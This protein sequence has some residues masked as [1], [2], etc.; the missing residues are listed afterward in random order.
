MTAKGEKTLSKLLRVNHK[1]VIFALGF[2]FKPMKVTKQLLLCAMAAMMFASCAN[3]NK[4]MKSSDADYK[5]EVA[6]QY[7]MRGKYENASLLLNDV[8]ASM[9]GTDKSDESLFLLGMCKYNSGDMVAANDYFSKYYTTY[10]SG[11]HVEE[12]YFYS[13]M[14]LFLST[15]E[16]SLDQT[17]TYNAVT[18]FQNFIEAYPQSKFAAEAR[19]L[20]FDLQDKLVEKE[21]LSAQLYYNLGDYFGNCTMGGSN[22]EAAIITAQNAIRDYPYTRRKEDFSILILRAKYDLAMRSIES[23]MK[24]RYNDAINDYYGFVNEYPKSK[25]MDEAKKIYEKAQKAIK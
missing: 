19:K 11:I 25:Y 4:V 2:C 22:Y 15:V 5:Y 16:P 1:N 17:A 6:K 18:E 14:S 20:I 10:T 9:K 24:D 8:L 21:Y 3:I 12:A 7:F 23:K 13:G